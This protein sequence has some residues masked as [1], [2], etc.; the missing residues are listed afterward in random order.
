[1]A[2][3]NEKRKRYGLKRMNREE[4]KRLKERL[5]RK[6]E[7]AQAKSNYWKWFRGDIKGGKKKETESVWLRLGEEITALEEGEDEDVPRLCDKA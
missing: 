7:L 6:I 4:N 3:A 2:I 5:D 1:M